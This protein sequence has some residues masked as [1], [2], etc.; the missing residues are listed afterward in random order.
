MTKNKL[1]KEIDRLARRAGYPH[2]KLD[3]H[4]YMRV[5]KQAHKNVYKNK[6]K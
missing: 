5:L 1:S 3:Y 2:L 6:P 4:T